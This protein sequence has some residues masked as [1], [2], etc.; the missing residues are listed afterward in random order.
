MIEKN[1]IINADCLEAMKDI[2]DGSIDLIVTDPPYIVNTTGGGGTV[3]KLL[4]LN[5]SLKD[6]D[7]AD[8]T[9]G[10][11]I[12]KFSKEV[13]RVQKDGINAYFW[14]NKLQIPE[15]FRVYVG[16]LNCKFDIL[17]WHKRNA[18]PTFH[19]KY[20]TDTEYCLYFRNG[21][22]GVKPKNYEDAQ[23]YSV[24]LI[25]HEDKKLYSHPTIK[26]LEWMQKIIRNSSKQGDIILD[27]FCG[28]GTTCVAAIR[29]KRHYIGIELNEEYFNIAK[30]R[31][32][33]ELN[34]P[35]LF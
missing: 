9:N 21:K 20:L 14:C 16:M 19:N 12:E 17:C 32:E 34:Q 33:N 31:I 3:N 2:P 22:G 26:P 30:K 11:D 27:P 23:T 6:L 24:G 15:Y 4:K 10:Y 35:T 8:I 29:E 25:N 7:K 28:S 1:S 18:L 5:E 13:Q